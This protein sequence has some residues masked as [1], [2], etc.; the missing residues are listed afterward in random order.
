MTEEA[1][2][3]AKQAAKIYAP[4]DRHKL[5]QDEKKLVKMLEDAGFII[6]NKAVQWLCG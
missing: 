5:S 3:I 1:V 6:Q 4:R 2:E